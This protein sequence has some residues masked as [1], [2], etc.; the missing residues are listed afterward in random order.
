[1]VENFNHLKYNWFEL[2]NLPCHS[3]ILLPPKFFPVNPSNVHFG[4]TA[5]KDVFL[6]K[7]L[8]GF[9][10]LTPSCDG[11]VENVSKFVTSKVPVVNAVLLVRKPSL[12]V[13]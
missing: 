10:L 12:A 1:M 7:L 13:S 5:T 4:L 8:A 2:E 9:Q 3:P 6:L 11:F